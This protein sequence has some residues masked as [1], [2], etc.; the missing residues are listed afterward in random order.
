MS[1]TPA[2]R[3]YS[4]ITSL[5]W[6]MTQDYLD[7]F[8]AI[9]LRESD[10]VEVVERKLGKRLDN[11]R[12]VTVRDGVA[13]IPI[14]GPIF[15]YADLFTQISGGVTVEAL[16]RDLDTALSDPAIRA[17]VL[18]IDSPGGELAGMHELA[19]MVFAARQ[20]K[21]I[22]AYVSYLGA[23]GAYWLASSAERIIVDATGM[24]GSIGV[25][26]AVRDPSKA[27]SKDIEFVSSQS[28]RKR[29]DPTTDE[30]RVAIQERIDALADVFIADVARNRGVD[31]EIVV[32]RFGRG[33]LLVGAQAVAAGMADALGSYEGLLTELSAPPVFMVSVSNKEYSAMPPEET[34]RDD[35]L[36]TLRKQ[37]AAE[38]S[39]RINS[40]ASSFV[41]LQIRD[42][43]VLPGE[44]QT[45]TTLY[46]QLAQDDAGS[47][48]SGESRVDLLKAA[49]AARPQHGLTLEA[50]PDEALHAAPNRVD[51]PKPRSEEQA[52]EEEAAT[53]ARKYAQRANG[54][55]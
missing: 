53:H 19:D 30:G 28:P 31:P 14:V 2:L 38:R 41:E 37:L 7:L 27:A 33:G 17:V 8:V 34:T 5:D 4:A 39:A 25:V 45:L 29:P 15:R 1:N 32:E 26:T 20:V 11:T 6:A 40:E 49:T 23:S 46:V 52:L 36:V 42:S 43:R 9:A 21:P 18:S 24:L 47:P 55:K 12:S 50:S 10:P 51:T 44:R 54:K 13:T 16:A 48:R 35:E 22:T 3:A